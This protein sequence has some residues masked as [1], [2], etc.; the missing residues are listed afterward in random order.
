MSLVANF[1]NGPLYAPIITGL[2][3]ALGLK[4]VFGVDDYMDLLR[5]GG[6]AAVS[7]FLADLLQTQLK[8]MGY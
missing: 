8:S 4:F 7:V 6:F 5:Y 3:V 2:I 1:I